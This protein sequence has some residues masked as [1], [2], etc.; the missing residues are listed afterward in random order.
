M[1]SIYLVNDKVGR[2]EIKLNEGDCPRT[3]KAFLDRLEKPM[4][5]ELSRWGDELYGTVDVSVPA[6]NPLEEC[7]VGDVAYWLQGSGFCILFGR[8]PASVGD[9]PQLISPGNIFGKIVGDSSVFKAFHSLRVRL[10]K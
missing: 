1:T 9:K 5:I 3:C 4:E 6:E 7:E 2:V 10:E 8:T